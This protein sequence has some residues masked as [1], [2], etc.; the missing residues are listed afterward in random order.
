MVV[1][2][3]VVTN[4]CT[5]LMDIIIF[6]YQNNHREIYGSYKFDVIIDYEWIIDAI[7]ILFKIQNLHKHFIN[8]FNY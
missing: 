7:T 1:N 5:C 4:K 8:R 2:S 6:R 3:F